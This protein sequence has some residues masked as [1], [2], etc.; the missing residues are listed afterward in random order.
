MG[1]LYYGP[2]FGQVFLLDIVQIHGGKFRVG[3]LWGWQVVLS[4]KLCCS[5][6]I[7]FIRYEEVKTLIIL[8]IQGLII[9]YVH[10]I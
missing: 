3:I 5:Y 6:L 9:L 10:S 7:H 4:V 1:I 2:N 8:V